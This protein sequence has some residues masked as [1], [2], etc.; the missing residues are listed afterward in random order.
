MTPTMG[1]AMRRITSDPVPPPTMMESNRILGVC[2]AAR[3]A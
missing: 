3:K 2:D 1:A